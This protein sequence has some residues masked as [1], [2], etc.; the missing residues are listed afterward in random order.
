MD[1][2]GGSAASLVLEAHLWA[3]YIVWMTTL[4]LT[5]LA[6]AILAI[7]ACSETDVACT[8][9]AR[10]STMVTVVDATGASVT[11]ATVT[12]SVDGAAAQNCDLLGSVYNCGFEQSGT[13]TITATRGTTSA[14][15]SVVVTRTTDGCSHVVTEKVTL[16]LG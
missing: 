14:T 6:T 8:T 2:A 11:D 10:A 9:E 13:L 16:T 3:S 5:L 15:K 7:S 1:R 4:N 12:Y